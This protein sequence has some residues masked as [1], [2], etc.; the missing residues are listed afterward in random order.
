M[1]AAREHSGP[2]LAIALAARLRLAVSNDSGIG[3]LLVAGECRLI[4]LFG[5]TDSR[6]FTSPTRP[7][8]ILEARHY[9]GREMQRIPY[10]AVAEAVEQSI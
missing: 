8:V 5:P 9:G 10:E 3:H 6:K 2:L 1:P 4:R 7:C